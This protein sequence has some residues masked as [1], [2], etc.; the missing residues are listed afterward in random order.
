[1]EP[2]L[3][4]KKRNN[5]SKSIFIVLSIILGQGLSLSSLYYM[6]YLKDTRENELKTSLISINFTEG[7]NNIDLTTVPVIDEIGMK[8]T[9]YT[10]SIKNTSDVSIDAK[11]SVDLISETNID[12]GAV[13]YAFYIDDELVKK[14]HI[15]PKNLVLYI[16]ENMEKNETLN[17]KVVFWI[18]YYYQQPSKV[19]KAKIKAEGISKDI[20]VPNE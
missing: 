12:L 9:P 10:F 6:Y 18:D 14:D 11:I 13:C 16:K 3:V 2:E 4:K 5:Q 17:C 1:M 7:A 8:N 19:F 15:D 20:I